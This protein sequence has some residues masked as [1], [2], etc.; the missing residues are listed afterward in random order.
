M[1]FTLD[2]HCMKSSSIELTI[3]TCSTLFSTKT[4][5]VEM[6]HAISTTSTDCHILTKWLNLKL[7]R[8][9]IQT[10]IN[11]SRML[12]IRIRRFTI[13]RKKCTISTLLWLTID[14]LCLSWR[15]MQMYSITLEIEIRTAAEYWIL[16]AI[17][18]D[19]WFSLSLIRMQMY[20]ITW[21]SKFRITIKHEILHAIAI[22]IV[23]IDDW[24]FWSF[25]CMQMYSITLKIKIRIA[26][27]Y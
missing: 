12:T 26:I 1:S 14:L 9:S 4:I 7:K 3:S 20:S 5:I 23:V 11:W 21:N 6:L 10:C 17:E 25:V 22:D 15:C 18:F 8:T 13:S 16:H 27:D 24:F 2:E 19:D